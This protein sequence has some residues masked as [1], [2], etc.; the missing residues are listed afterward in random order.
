MIPVGKK[1]VSGVLYEKVEC[2][3]CQGLGN[4]PD[5]A[6]QGASCVCEGHGKVWSGEDGSYMSLYRPGKFYVDKP[7]EKT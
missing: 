4:T 2:P 1:K 3:V 5:L 7:G 6:R